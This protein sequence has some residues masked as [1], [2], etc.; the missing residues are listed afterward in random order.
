[1]QDTK[2]NDYNN[3]ICISIIVAYNSVEDVKNN[4]LALLKQTVKTKKTII[5]DNSILEIRQDIQKVCELDFFS[6]LNIKYVGNENNKGSAAGFAQGMLAAYVDGAEWIWIHDQDGYPEKDCLE[7][8][9]YYAEKNVD[10]PCILAPLIK[11]FDGNY[12]NYF[13]C[14]NNFFSR[15]IG[16]STKKNIYAV[17]KVGSAGILINRRSIEMIGV[18]DS[19]N[20]FVNLEDYDYC[21]RLIHNYGRIF[22]IQNAVYYHP[23]LD[24]KYTHQYSFIK[25]FIQ[26]Y[27]FCFLPP[28]LGAVEKKMSY[29]EK[30]TAYSR[31]YIHIKY[32]NL[33][34]ILMIGCFSLC[35]LFYRSLFNKKILIKK[36][37]KLYKTIL[38]KRIR[39]EL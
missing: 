34:Q 29:R 11:D 33:F 6:D 20:Y 27:I 8:L 18:Y 5:V 23:D 14:K 13:R 31:V 17:E 4:L 9:L 21:N 2:F 32:N 28:F 26:K 25:R 12:L 19:K 10:F 3:I 16:V 30:F 35:L 24:K 36:T 1:M 37:L 22:L 7:K 39:M 38:K 15:E